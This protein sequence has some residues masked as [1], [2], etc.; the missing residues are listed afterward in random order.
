[1]GVTTGSLVERSEF[2]ETTKASAELDVPGGL[3]GCSILLQVLQNATYDLDTPT[4]DNASLKS[5][6]RDPRADADA[7]TSR[8]LGPCLFRKASC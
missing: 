3:D 6:I 5:P 4:E 1:M 8:H 2:P 7:S